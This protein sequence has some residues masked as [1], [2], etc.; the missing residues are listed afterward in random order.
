LALLSRQCSKE[1]HVFV[2]VG[3]SSISPLLPVTSEY[4]Q[5]LST[6]KRRKTKIVE[7]EVAIIAVLADGKE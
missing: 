3:I 1:N 4:W 6:Y 7:R 2:I 5:S